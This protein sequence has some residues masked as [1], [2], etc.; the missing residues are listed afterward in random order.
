MSRI[1]AVV[2]A[3]SAVA[4]SK[5][6]DTIESAESFAKSRGVVL[7][8]KTEDKGQVVAPR[9]YD[10]KAGDVEVAI[11]QFHTSDAAGKW[12]EMMDDSPFAPEVRV[13]KGNVIFMVWGGD[14]AARQK[15][16][17]ALQP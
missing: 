1:L 15:V 6:L 9:S 14:D 12:K 5:G 2:L 7:T 10:Y 13:H 8:E 4:C 3:L 11:M 17:A 16:V